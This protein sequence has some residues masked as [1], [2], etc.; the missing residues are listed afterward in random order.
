MEELTSEL[1][2]KYKPDFTYKPKDFE[3]F[4]QARIEGLSENPQEVVMVDRNYPVANVEV[5]DITFKSWDGTPIKG[6]LV[7]PRFV[8]ECP[9][10][11]SYPGYTGDRGLPIDYLKWTSLGFAVYSFDVRGQGDSPDYA[12]YKNGSRIPG[13]MLHGIMEPENYYYVNVL[14]D[15]ILQLNWIKANASFTIT[16]IGLVGSSQGGGI[17]LSVGG[18]DGNLDFIAADYPFST[19]YS[20]SLREASRGTYMEINNFF[21]LHDPTYKLYDTVFKTLSYVDSIYFCPNILC[22]VLMSTG[23]EDKT[24]P[25]SS[26]F[27]AYNSLGAVDKHIEVYPNYEHE[28]NPFHEEKKLEFIAKQIS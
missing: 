16:K 13:W 8:K 12:K 14:K 6:I 5:S 10:I 28:F 15:S 27:V 2:K 23:L 22:P 19:N 26:A 21:K 18:L 3:A 25:P 20:L 4:W 9:V 11:I 17:A 7:K 24:T 1:L